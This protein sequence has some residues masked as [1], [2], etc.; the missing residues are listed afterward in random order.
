MWLTLFLLGSTA[1]DCSV[2]SCCQPTPGTLQTQLLQALIILPQYLKSNCF[3]QKCSESLTCHRSSRLEV[4]LQIIQPN[5][6]KFYQGMGIGIDWVQRFTAPLLP[7][8]TDAKLGQR[9]CCV[10]PWGKT[11]HP[12]AF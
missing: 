7:C 5:L 4:A 1:L 12:H 8:P 10:P 6:P 2:R 9:T 11:K 3:L